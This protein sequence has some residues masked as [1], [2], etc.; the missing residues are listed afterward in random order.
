M[1]R[2][3]L[4]TAVA[5]ATLACPAIV[6]VSAASAKTVVMQT[7]SAAL[8][9]GSTFAWAPTSSATVD[10]AS[11]GLAN[12]I[13][14]KR[15]K[16]AI[17]SALAS[18]GYAHSSEGADADLAVSFHVVVKQEKGVRVN[19]NAGTICGWR[20]CLRTWSADP[21]VSEYNYTQGQ[22]VID[23]V[24][25]ETGALV[26][27]AVSERRVSAGDVTQKELNEVVTRMMKSL[28]QV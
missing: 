20:G 2:L 19:D 3:I 22:L 23:L 28:P 6:P 27:R 25:R 16:S 15:L 12:E 14:A 13:T 17:E 1:K 18:H 5:T 9:T 8:A 24:D 11:A 26:W 10:P 7:G 21:M 4:I